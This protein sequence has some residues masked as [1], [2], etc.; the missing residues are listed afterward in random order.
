M[1][2]LEAFQ[3]AFPLPQLPATYGRERN[4]HPLSEHV[5]L[6]I[7]TFPP[8]GFCAEWHWL[9]A[10]YGCCDVFLS[11]HR[12][13]G[14]GRGMAEALQLGVDVITTDFGGNT[15]FC[16]GPL[17][18]PVRYRPAPIPRDAY[19]CA[20]GHRWAEPDL[21]HEAELCREVAARRL[22]LA[23]DPRVADPSRD[24]AVLASYRERFS[25]AVVGGRYRARLEE[26]WADRDA[27]GERLR[28][29]S[30]RSPVGW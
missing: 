23:A 14:F 15:D 5:A 26:L 17:A 3:L 7:K 6:L 30:D 13:E 12:S 11:L 9:Q 24:P 28:W 29:R 1:A 16:S 18:H 10:L 8:Q 20:D 27:I 22:A 19:P 2:A 21:E 4:V 25:F